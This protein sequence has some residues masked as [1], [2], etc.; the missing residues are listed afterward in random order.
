MSARENVERS[1]ARQRY[2]FKGNRQATFAENV[3]LMAKDY[4]TD[5]WRP[6]KVLEKLGPVTYS[7]L[8]DDTRVWKRYV[9]QLPPCEVRNYESQEVDV[10]D[11]VMRDVVSEPLVSREAHENINVRAG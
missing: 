11:K 9:D 5:R 2:Y 7:M 10:S 6:V 1:Q 8:T 4:A 3:R